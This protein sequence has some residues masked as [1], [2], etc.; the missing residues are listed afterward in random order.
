MSGRQ[1]NWRFSRCANRFRPAPRTRSARYAVSLGDAKTCVVHYSN[2]PMALAFTPM[3]IG[4]KKCLRHLFKLF[5]QR[6]CFQWFR[7]LLGVLPAEHMRRKTGASLQGAAIATSYDYQGISVTVGLMSRATVNGSRFAIGI[8]P[9]CLGRGPCRDGATVRHRRPQRCRGDS[10]P[11]RS[12]KMPATY[13][14][15]W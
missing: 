7:S 3:L 14:L 10:P 8:R 1:S 9:Y 13:S 4:Q 15:S 11:S 5:A 2:R 6:P 12:R